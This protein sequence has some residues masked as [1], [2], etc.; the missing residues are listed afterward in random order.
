VGGSENDSK[1]KLHCS[2]LLG[3]ALLWMVPVRCFEVRK[4]RENRSL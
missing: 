2:F 4:G 3:L 1:N